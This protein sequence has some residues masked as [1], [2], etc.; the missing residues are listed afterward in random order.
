MSHHVLSF[1]AKKPESQP[2]PL[3]QKKPNG[4]SAEVSAQLSMPTSRFSQLSFD[5]ADLEKEPLDTAEE[6]PRPRQ[7]PSADPLHSAEKLAA[8]NRQKTA[9]LP[10]NVKVC[11][12][13]FLSTT[14]RAFPMSKAVYEASGMEFGVVVES[15]PLLKDVEM[16]VIDS[17]SCAIVRCKTCRAYLNPYVVFENESTFFVYL[18]FL[19]FFNISVF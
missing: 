3:A 6:A 17:G 12:A 11:P 7:K 15:F 19:Q 18:E 13:Q 9:K 2:K 16:P 1:P 5:R 8:R 4:T 14:H 10:K